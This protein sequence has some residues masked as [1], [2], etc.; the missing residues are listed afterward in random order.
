MGNINIP[1]KLAPSNQTQYGYALADAINIAGQK[2]VSTLDDLFNIYDWRLSPSSTNQNDDAIGQEWYVINQNK[3]YRL[4]SWENRRNINGWEPLV[5]ASDIKIYDNYKIEVSDILYDNINNALSFNI[6]FTCDD[7]EVEPESLIVMNDNVLISNSLSKHISFNPSNGVVN[8]NIKIN[9]EIEY[10]FT[11][12]IIYTGYS[13][14]SELTS[15][16][17]LTPDMYDSISS[18][19]IQNES[20]MYVYFAC[21]I[22]IDVDLNNITHKAFPY[23]MIKNDRLYTSNIG[24]YYTY[25][26]ASPQIAMK[27]ILDI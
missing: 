15:L 13:E 3:K 5:Y 1:A 14:D 25:R 4:I 10:S 26:S 16:L 2:N 27:Y 18:V 22:S 19:S 17:S 9:D 7:V 21:P 23:N 12:Y 24:T 6:S 11:K 20:N 8:V